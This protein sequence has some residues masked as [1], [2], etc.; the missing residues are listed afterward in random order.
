M[1]SAWA[2]LP[3]TSSQSSPSN[4]GAALPPDPSPTSFTGDR[5]LAQ[6]ILFMR[7]TILSKGAA[8]AVA[9]GDVGTVYKILKVRVLGQLTQS[10]A[11]QSYCR[12]YPVAYFRI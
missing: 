6:S 2:L 11:L 10:V 7:D 4:T 5:V 9:Q 12:P 8:E 3:S 1:G